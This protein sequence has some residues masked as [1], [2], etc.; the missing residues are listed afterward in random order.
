MYLNVSQIICGK[1]E[2]SNPEVF[3]LSI[4]NIEKILI[5]PFAGWSAKEWNFNKFVNLAKA[6]SSTYK[7]SFLI[8][9][10]SLTKDIEIEIKNYKIDIIETKSVQE[11]I[12]ALKNCSMLIGNDSGP[13]HIASMLG[14]ATFAIYGPSNPLYTL[15][16]GEAHGYYQK[17]IKCSPLKNQNLCFTDGG[18]YGCPSFECMNQISPEEVLN[19]IKLFISNVESDKLA[20]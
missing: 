16:K 4:K 20:Y 9:S 19:I 6:L 7:I 2:Y 17:K 13:I 15:P 11:L 12:A 3:P 14:K 8:P 1:S 10:N 18:R 5:H